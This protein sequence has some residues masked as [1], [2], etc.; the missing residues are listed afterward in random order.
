MKNKDLKKI[1]TG[2]GWYFLRKGN[3]HEIWT[4]CK[5]INAIPRHRE[6]NENTAKSIIKVAAANPPKEK[7]K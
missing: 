1:L 3:S 5:D 2:L 4:N 6:I 7:S